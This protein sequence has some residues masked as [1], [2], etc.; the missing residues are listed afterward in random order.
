MSQLLTSS[1]GMSSVQPDL[2][3][4]LVESAPEGVALCEARG[5]DWP[6]VFVNPAMEQLTGYSAD[7]M[8]GRNLR[9]LQADDR[10]QEGVVKIKNA[11]RDGD[12]CHALIRNYRRDGTMF[13]NE[14]RLVPIRADD[15][16]ITHF[17]SFHREGATLRTDTREQRDPSMSTQTMM[18]YLRD[19]KLTGLLRRPY[20]EDLIKRDWGLAQRESRR[21]SFLVFDLD[22]F[23]AY[24]DVFGRQ[25]A[26][27]S[28]RRIARVIGGCFRRASDLCGRFDE[29]QIAALTTG[30]DLS[31][32]AKL[33]DAVLGRV[34][35]LAIHHPRSSVLRYVTASAGVVSMVPPHDVPPER[36]YDAALKALK[37]A[38][39][40]GRNRAVSRECD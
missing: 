8:V 13:W 25:G 16:Q 21:L 34:R 22:H 9:F 12:A 1:T 28:F 6:V 29:D 32:A 7:Q 4:H 31:Q 11:L 38:K 2:L 10:D 39:E 20:F 30:L 36:I 33:A 18:A 3:K 27:Q 26:D 5:G 35:D 19:D 24:R 15:G 14:M 40:L 37:D 23:A 17:A